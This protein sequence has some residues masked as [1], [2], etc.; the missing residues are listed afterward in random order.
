MR[1]SLGM[2]NREEEIQILDRFERDDP[3]DD[4]EA[5]TSVEELRKDQE[6]YKATYV[7]PELKGY[8]TDICERTRN[9]GEI[10]GGV[11][12]RG[13]IALYQAVRAWAYLQGRAYVVPEDVKKLALPV[14]SHRLILGGGFQKGEELMARI[15]EEV[16]V[17][18]EEW[19][20]R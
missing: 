8:I 19:G 5:V 9:T 1:L 2:P 14:L 15:L 4:L 3:L 12:P 6:A 10:L 20:K 18:T 11:S 17:P 13:T 16:P 7:H